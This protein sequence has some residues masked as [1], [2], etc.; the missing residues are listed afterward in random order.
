MGYVIGVDLGT[1]SLKGILA[2]ADGKIVA[3]TSCAHDPVYPHS[4]WAEQPVEDYL[5]SFTV[6]V[7]G[8]L[9]ESHVPAEEV[10]TIGVD[11]INDSASSS[12]ARVSR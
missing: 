11:T 9:A 10:G 3:E 12:M 2:D 6:V 1:Q 8:L 7:Q 5:H 4:G